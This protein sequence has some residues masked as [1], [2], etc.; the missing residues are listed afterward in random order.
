MKTGTLER[1]FDPEP[2]RTLKRRLRANKL[3][4][5][6][7][8]THETCETLTKDAMGDAPP[9]I[10]MGDYYKRIDNDQSSLGFQPANPANFDI[11]GN[12]LKGLQPV[13][14]THQQ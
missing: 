9:K 7:G 2:G 4:K 6:K 1:E 3:A 12:V 8:C 10:T 11:K 5:E 14:Q 13:R